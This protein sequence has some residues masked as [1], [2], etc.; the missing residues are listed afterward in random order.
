MCRRLSFIPLEP[1]S[2]R[3]NYLHTQ[4]RLLVVR[5]EVQNEAL[6]DGCQ[7]DA[8][9]LLRAPELPV[10]PS[11]PLPWFPATPPSGVMCIGILAWNQVNSRK[12]NAGIMACTVS[13]SFKGLFWKDSNP[14]C[15]MEGEKEHNLQ[16]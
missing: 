7:G 12:V 8:E 13:L 1:V 16:Q 5:T 4:D 3:C 6:S 2:A 15:R 9:L 11:N 10:M 14:N